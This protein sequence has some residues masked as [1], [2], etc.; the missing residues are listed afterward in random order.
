[1]AGTVGYNILI[2]KKDEPAAV[3]HHGPIKKISK[4]N[5][6]LKKSLQSFWCPP[7]P[8][9]NPTIVIDDNESNIVLEKGLKIYIIKD[10][11]IIKSK[12]IVLSGLYISRISDIFEEFIRGPYQVICE[13]TYIGTEGYIQIHYDSNENPGDQVHA[14]VCQWK[15]DRNKLQI[16]NLPG[17][18]RARKF[19]HIHKDE[20]NTENY[21]NIRTH[22]INNIDPKI[23]LRKFSK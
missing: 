19:H 14:H 1:M 15:I 11:K 8:N 21:L 9:I 13:Y 10:K 17:K 4:S 2:N 5:N 20:N 7:N 22:L 6:E 18:K 12:N 16:Q 3:W 23:K